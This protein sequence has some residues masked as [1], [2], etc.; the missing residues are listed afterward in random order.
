[1][2]D[3]RIFT[4]TD[5]LNAFDAPAEDTYF[6]QEE[7]ARHDFR[8]RRLEQD[9]RDTLILSVLRSLDSFNQVGEHRHPIW[10]M[11][12]GEIAER[13]AASKNDL[14]A[15]E[16]SFISKSTHIRLQGD[17]AL[18]L[19]TGFEFNYF[20]VLRRWLFVK[21]LAKFQRVWEFGCGSGFNLAALAQLAPEKELVGLDWAY[22]AVDLINHVA[23]F[24]GFRLQG[25]HFDLFHPDPVLHLEKNTAV[26]TFCAL[27]QIGEGFQQFLDW[28]IERRPG[29]VIHMEPIADFY[30]SESL[31]DNIAFR[32][33]QGRKYLQG[34]LPSLRKLMDARQ[35]ELIK[36]H[37][38]GMGSLYHEGYSLLIWRPM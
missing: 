32:Y 18:P 6:V 23:K 31:Y 34:Y 20:R 3:I 2:K 35:I 33:H 7:I 8:Y 17:Y 27:E 5:F 38:L 14:A 30:N 22:S 29:L 1:M 16:P 10:E 28:L 12:W 36:S 26:M 25:R 24:H 19:T 21:Y 9:E 4:V 13:Y 11:A 15:L 37:R